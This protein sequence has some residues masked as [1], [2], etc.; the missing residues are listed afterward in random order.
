[1]KRDNT[2]LDGRWLRTSDLARAAGIHVNTV[3]FYESISFLPKIKRD[4]NNGYR[5]FERWHLSQI[6]LIQHLM[7]VTWLGGRIR[8]AA[9][10]TILNAAQR[11]R[12]EAAES[13]EKLISYLRVEYDRAE[14]AMQILEQWAESSSSRND[15]NICGP[16][17]GLSA[18]EGGL[19]R[20]EISRLL[21][22]GPERIR[23]WERNGLLDVPRMPNGYR[24]YGQSELER[25]QVIQALL[26]CGYRLMPVRKA[27]RLHDEYPGIDVREIIET[28]HDEIETYA[29]ANNLL[30]TLSDCIDYAVAGRQYIPS[31]D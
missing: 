25:L 1:M 3:R 24:V 28:Y 9:I 12:L 18:P 29:Q 30:T 14:S 8:K 7:K 6:F 10:D 15:A 26:I 11:E 27:L 5:L 21:G 4:P 19:S 23:N 20:R 31:G 2:K 22:I 16:S 17:G 13:L